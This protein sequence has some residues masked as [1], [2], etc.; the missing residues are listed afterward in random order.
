[1]NSLIGQ[2]TDKHVCLGKVKPLSICLGEYISKYDEIALVEIAKTILDIP[3]Y[4]MKTQTK[5][6]GM[7]L[8][9]HQIC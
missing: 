5:R 9:P 3:V 6:N 7:R 8:V 2:V 4:K 1:M